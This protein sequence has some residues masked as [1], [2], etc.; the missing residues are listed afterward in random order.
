M[1]VVTWI[2]TCGRIARDFAARFHREATGNVAMIFALSLPALVLMTVGGVDIHRASTVR[3]NLQDA[4]DAATLAAARS[5]Y[6]SDVDL[7]RVGVSALRANLQAYPDIILREDLTT[8]TLNANSVVIA[9][10]KVDVKTLVANIILPPYG[11]FMNDYLPVGAHSEVDRSSKNIEVSLVL[12]ITGSMSGS[13]IQDLKVAANELV[14]I[15]VQNVQTPYYTRM[16]IV[17]Y[18]IGVN[19][20]GY[21]NGARGTPIGATNISNAA[22]TIGSSKSISNI[23]RANPGVVSASSHGFASGDFIWIN[24]VSGMSQIND[25]AY[26]VKYISANSFSLETWNGSFWNSLS[27][28]SGYS[29]YSSGGTIRKCLVSDCSVVVT[30]NG[31]N[32]QNGDGVYITGVKGMTQINGSPY[33]VGN[34]TSNTFSIGVNGV[35]WGTYS[36]SGSAW[37]GNDGCQWRVYY[38]PY[39]S[40]RAL[41]I[42]SCASERTGPQR[43]T[44]ASPATS[45]VGTNYPSSQC[46]A[47]VVRPLS[48]DKSSIKSLINSLSVT[49][50]TAGQ[51]GIG[52]GWYT[53]SPN[54]NGLWPSQP[55]GPYAPSQTLKAVII[56]TDGEFNTAYST[57]VIAQDMGLGSA[58][59]L[60]N[61]N[62]TNGDPFLQGESLCTAM[63]AQ[64]VVVYTVGFQITAGGNA[65]KMLGRCATSPAHVFLPASGGDLSQAF[66]AIGRDITRLRISR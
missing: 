7:T 52:W 30:S 65:E 6:T 13:K 32:L 66:A 38:N 20:G 42:S 3:I 18:S 54:F 57:G 59:N 47:A 31:H 40:L 62:A 28:S 4:L 17:P 15:V 12:D 34:S 10:S 29:S 58:S 49:G 26:R 16:A 11:K 33:I 9:Q 50:A 8:F 19:L 60:I 46:P 22:W 53:V 36:S 41:E 25:R 1:G 5:P 63:K 43:Y 21:A 48:S 27:T 35:N 14:D 23:T 45:R 39:G 24:G 55:A 2:R 37:C 56:M 64:G 44:D 51:I 61:Q